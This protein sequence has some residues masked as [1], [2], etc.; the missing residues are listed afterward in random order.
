M[1][2]MDRVRVPPRSAVAARLDE[3]DE[4]AVV[5]PAGGQVAD[6]ALVAEPTDSGAD[7]AAGDPALSAADTTDLLG[8]AHPTADD[9]L[10]ARDGRSLATLTAD[11]CGAN[12]L[13]LAPCAGW[14]LE[15]PRFDPEPAGCR[16]I[17]RRAL[18]RD[19]VDP[20]PRIDALNCFMDTT[21][22][23][24]GAVGVDPSPATP[25]DAVTLVTETPVAVGVSACPA[26]N[27]D[28]GING[29]RPGPVAVRLPGGIDVSRARVDGV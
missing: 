17:L 25:G 12:D 15:P 11:D 4:F 24:D 23:P 8:T 13:L 27:A 5:S 16:E 1:N 14:M 6:L 21:L 29:D 7:R 19:G 26:V 3:G 10:F 9:R 28:S 18:D 22:G 2:P 20:V